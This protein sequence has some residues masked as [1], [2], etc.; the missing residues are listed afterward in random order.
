MFKEFKLWDFDQ[1][2]IVTL[3]KILQTNNLWVTLNCCSVT[4]VWF[5]TI[6][7]WLAYSLLD[8]FPLLYL[9][10]LHPEGWFLQNMLP[11]LLCQLAAGQFGQYKSLAECGTE[12]VRRSQSLIPF[13][14]CFGRYFWQLHGPRSPQA[15]LPWWPPFLPSLTTLELLAPSAVTNLWR[16]HSLF[17][18]S[19]LPIPCK[20]YP[21]LNPF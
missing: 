2:E 4:C 18:L 16:H 15:A 7:V 5:W 6:S 17:A 13:F 3:V 12:E 14:P 9:L 19:A 11:R 1:A 10:C 20:W 21:K 8:L